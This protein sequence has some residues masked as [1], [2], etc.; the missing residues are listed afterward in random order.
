MSKHSGRSFDDMQ[1]RVPNLKKIDE[2]IGFKP[3]HNLDQI[4][5]SVIEDQ[6]GK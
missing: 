3:R 5:D 4:I 2:M 1:R 6:R